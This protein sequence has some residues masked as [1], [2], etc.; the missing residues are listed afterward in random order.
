MIPHPTTWQNA[1]ERER[2]HLLAV[3]ES[4]RR[5]RSGFLGR[6]R[7]SPIR[8]APAVLPPAVRSA[9]SMLR[10]RYRIG[11]LRLLTR[12]LAIRV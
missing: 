9:P 7:M 1:R 5:D 2:Q 10:P 3:A 11:R 8:V 6:R 4:G 12:L